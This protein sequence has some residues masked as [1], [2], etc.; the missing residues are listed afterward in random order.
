[1]SNITVKF[2]GKEYSIPEDVLTYIDLLDFTD[3]VHKNLAS[4]FVR[5][6]RNEIAKDN[7]G[8]LGDEDLAAEIEQQVGKYIAKLCDNGIFTRTI[9]DYLKNNKGYQLYSDVNKAALEKMKSLLIQEMDAWQAGYENAVNKAESHVTGMGFSIWSSSFVNHAI[10]AAM[11][12]STLNKQGKE[13]EAQYQKDMNDLRS[14]LDSQYGGEKSNYIN[15]TYIPNMEAALTVFA[16]ELL[17]KYVADM[18]ANGKF[19]SKTLDYVDIGRSNDLLKNLTLS[20]NKQAVLENAFAACP[21]NIAVYMQAMKYDLLDYDS[22]QTAKVFKQDHHVL[23]FFRESWGEVS[24]PTKFNI[25]YHCINVWASLTGKSSA[26]L[27]RG[28]TDKYAT[29]V[30]KA[31]S[32]VADMLADKSRCVSTIGELRDDVVLSGD[33]IC[34]GKAREYI[35]PIVPIRIWEQLTEQCGHSDLLDRIKKYFPTEKALHSKKD[36]DEYVLDRLTIA[37]EEARQVVIAQIGERKQ[38]EE[39]QRIERERRKAEQEKQEQERRKKNKR[40]AAIVTPIIAVVVVF[41]IILNTVIIPSNKYSK[42]ISL[43]ESG[44]YRAA[45]ELYNSLGDYKDATERCIDLWGKITFRETISAEYRHTVALKSNGT[46]VAVG[47]DQYGRTDVSDWTDI[48]AVSAGINYTLGLKSDGTVVAVGADNN[49]KCEVKSWRNIVAIGAGT[50]HSVGLKS[51]G[52]V[53]AIGANS[54][55]ECDVSGW[56]N[57]IAIAVGDSHTVGLKT[58]G[59]VVATGGTKYG[60]CDVEDWTD[61]VA[62]AAGDVYTLGL[63][64][65][66]TVVYAGTGSYGL[67]IEYVEEWT[68]IIA[69]SASDNHIL[70]LKSDGTVVVT[71]DNDE[72]Q[73]NVSRWKN[74]V[75]IAAG[76]EHSVGLM[77]DGTV[78][79]TGSNEYGQCNVSKWK[80]IRVSSSN[81]EYDK[82]LLDKEKIEYAS[83]ILGRRC[84]ESGNISLNADLGNFINGDNP[85]FGEDGHFEL[86]AYAEDSKGLKIDTLDWLS[87]GK[88][89]DFSKIVSA[90]K[91]LYGEPVDSN[92]FGTKYEWTN[93]GIYS[94]ILC[95]R[96]ADKSV[97]IR[98]VYR[99]SDPEDQ[100]LDGTMK[101]DLE[102]LLGYASYINGAAENVL[103]DYPHF[104]D[105]GDTYYQN[106][107]SLFEIEGYYKFEYF[108]GNITAVRFTWIPTDWRNDEEYVVECLKKCFGDFTGYS[109][110]LDD[111]WFCYTWEDTT[112]DNLKVYYYIAEDEGE[113]LVRVK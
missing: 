95:E 34:K 104:E 56:T 26:D 62:I 96:N 24:F 70:G 22:F 30:V 73:C 6:L 58:D 108:K 85:L 72:G 91:S 27:L 18:I 53:V 98:W 42:A 82:Y 41:F 28:L 102:K 81:I 113:I 51:D 94:S 4:T 76:Y 29:G 17:D 69:I 84:D 9:S 110:L 87:N 47:D 13:A 103:K 14:R 21:Y 49:D 74:I 36:L 7:I 86:G 46:V 55:D 101:T 31:Y 61:I 3:G 52:T 32:R 67:I 66:G 60:R 48:I 45:I 100:V 35:D 77:A 23:S 106:M 107:D 37:F 38:E 97:K 59:T 109:E 20:N 15:N 93:I 57:I 65:D 99:I 5:K 64:A 19:D 1:M 63:K 8:L 71:G 75:A 50:D 92:I 112:A 90:L 44:D 105:D 80:D 33:S 111:E 12:A 83:K 89:K 10:Y 78:V 2:L 43:Q 54:D 68:D 40:I 79:A 25:N 16:Y 88:V 11:E 39:R